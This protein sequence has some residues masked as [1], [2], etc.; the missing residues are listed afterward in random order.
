MTGL[1]VV[2]LL[3]LLIASYLLSSQQYVWDAFLLLG[4]A[5]VSLWVVFHRTFGGPCWGWG[6]WRRFLLRTWTGRIQ[7]AAVCLSLAVA[8]I[9]RKPAQNVNYALLLGMWLSAIGVFSA[10]LIL[11]RFKN[12]T[13]RW[14]LSLLESSLLAVLLLIAAA[15]RGVGL[16]YIPVNLGGDEGTQL[17]AGL[18]LLAHPMDN[19][20]A[21]GWYSVPTMSF[22]VYGVTMR[23]LG[24]TIA[25]GRALSAVAGTLTVLA[26]FGLART[27]GGRKVGWLAAIVLTFSAYHIHYSRLASNQILDP[28]IGT[29]S[30]WLLWY[31]ATSP[32]ES[33]WQEPAWGIAGIVT[34]LGWYAYFGARWVTFLLLLVLACYWI[35]DPHFLERCWRGLLLFAGGWLIVTL[36]L[37]G[38]YATHPTAL[39]ER[40]NAV[41]IFASGWLAREVTVTGKSALQLLLVQFW[42]AL[43]A[44]HLTPDPTFWY[45][46]QRPLLDFVT[47][48]LMLVGMLAS[49]MR[50]KWPSRAATLLWFWTT[51]V[52]AWG[53]TENPP[54]SQR[55]LLLVP[56][57]ALLVAWGVVALEEVFVGWRREFNYVLGALLALSAVFNLY[58]YFGTYT[59]RRVYGNPSAE[60]ATAFAHFVL[61]HPFPACEMGAERAPA[62]TYFFGPPE[63]YW[64]F[65]TIAFLLRDLPGVNVLPEDPLPAAPK[66]ARF[67]FTPNRVGELAEVEAQHPHGQLAEIRAPDG[68]LLMFLYD[69]PSEAEACLP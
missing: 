28:L 63:L 44:F 1:A 58:F 4:L 54:S 46:P 49:F 59:P 45:F 19:P 18:D 64:E 24:A 26:T 22:F 27:M 40:Y 67:A 61:T 41:S 57:V 2:A 68:R 39:A 15:V 69:W 43:T 17:L 10:S 55:G 33:R 60:K 66:P 65:G 6:R 12:C 42:K 35:R 53:M 36:P 56:A 5:V 48:G 9:A 25:G 51:L 62:T 23:L 29:L 30:L 32:A 50:W 34:G 31:A 13:M 52:M 20:F 14:P 21:T 11:P 8:L 7:V 3:V 38:W 16:G 37:L 47:G